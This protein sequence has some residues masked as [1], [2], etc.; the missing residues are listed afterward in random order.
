MSPPTA[1]VLSVIELLASRPDHEFK[2]AEIVDRLGMSKATCH[3]VVRTLLDAGYLVRS[4]RTKAY[5]LGPALI[6]AGRAAESAYPATRLA[7][8]IVADLAR[9]HEAECVASIIED[10]VITVVDWAGPKPG[11]GRGPGP[12]WSHVGQRLPLVPPFGAAQVAWM[13]EGRVDEW[14]TRAASGSDLA[15]LRATLDAIRR[16]GYD[17]QSEN[18]SLARFRETLAVFDTESL[19][20]EMRHA[21]GVLMGAVGRV[22]NLPARLEPD[23]RYPVSTIAA[24][25][26]DSDGCP[27]LTLSIRVGETLTG[28]EIDALGQDLRQAATEI[29][30]AAGGHPPPRL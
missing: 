15:G 28:T 23:E 9:R 18:A 27:A 26:F 7:G 16:R 5:L 24:P 10:D 30:E 8:P 17:V 29:T 25:V 14:L 21:V 11:P 13:D 12:A 2:L 19:T 4:P 20:D 3:A 1:R 6:A 22:E